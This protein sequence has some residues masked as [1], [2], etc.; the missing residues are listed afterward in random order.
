MIEVHNEFVDAADAKQSPST[1]VAHKE[2]SND[3]R[4]YY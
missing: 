2:N 1:A 3:N 4:N